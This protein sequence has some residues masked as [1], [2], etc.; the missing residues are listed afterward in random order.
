MSE[1]IKMICKNSS[2]YNLSIGKEYQSIELIPQ[3]ITPNFT[4][5]RYVSFI[6]DDGKESQGHAYRFKTLD[7]ICVDEYIKNNIKDT[8]DKYQ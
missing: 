7:G 6:D 3:L 1:Q 5:P 8:Y 2:G 4:F